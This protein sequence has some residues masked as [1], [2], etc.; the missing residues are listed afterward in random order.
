M[1][2]PERTSMVMPARPA[3]EPAALIPTE[4]PVGSREPRNKATLPVMPMPIPIPIPMS[5]PVTVPTA[6]LPAAMEPP[7]VD[8]PPWPRSCPGRATTR[9]S[10]AANFDVATRTPSLPW[11]AADPSNTSNVSATLELESHRGGPVSLT[12]YYRRED[13]ARVGYHAVLDRAGSEVG[14]GWLD[15]REDGALAHVEEVRALRL[16]SDDARAISLDFG[17]ATDAGGAGFDGFTL[18]AG[19]S[20]LTT[21]EQDGVPAVLGFACPEV[22]AEPANNGPPLQSQL[23]AGWCEARATRRLRIR[24]NLA[25]HAA[26]MT[27]PWNAEQ[28]LATSNLSIALWAND[29]AGMTAQFGLHFRKVSHERWD[30]HVTLTSD[31]PGHELGSGS[32]TFDEMG[33]LVRVRVDQRLLFPVASGA[34][35]QPIDLDFGDEGPNRPAS[36]DGV[37]AFPAASF[38]IAAQQDGHLLT[39]GDY[40]TGVDVEI[41]QAKM[42]RCGGQFT[43]L[44]S[45]YFLITGDMPIISETSDPALEPSAGEG[46]S[47]ALVY[48]ALLNAVPLEVRL[49]RVAEQKWQFLLFAGAGAQRV[50]RARFQFQFDSST[51]A[52][53]T[54]KADF[55]FDL[56][57][58]DGSAGAPI[59]VHFDGYS[60]FFANDMPSTQINPDGSADHCG[61]P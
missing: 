7:S 31:E 20:N 55:N 29:G 16:F 26:P 33:R 18:L 51:G 45:P 5:T 15:F 32:L 24:A 59:T 1:S 27:L 52:A 19:P 2:P 23:P 46:S 11:D 38:L 61:G 49:R 12:M 44:L 4:T 25:A 54:I 43:T 9:V 8:S 13:R 22:T 58:P 50:E 34:T 21:L 42:P 40:C 3:A 60:V 17:S 10:V 41:S 47:T 53:G 57:L 6:P 28:P 37:T 30:Y 39:Q 35:A 14:S 36:V 48:D 56:P